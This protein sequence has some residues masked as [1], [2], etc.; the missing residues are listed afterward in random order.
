MAAKIYTYN[1]FSGL[2]RSAVYSELTVLPHIAATTDLAAAVKKNYPEFLYT[3]SMDE[4]QKEL[5]S[6][7]Q[8]PSAVFQQHVL[9]G[10]ILRELGGSE[11]HSPVYQSCL[12][13]KKALLNTI[14]SLSA[15]ALSPD[16]I[17]PSN[18]EMRLLKIIWTAFKKQAE[19]LP[20][21]SRVLTQFESD[22]EA[23]LDRL[24]CVWP[25]FSGNAVVM[26]GFFYITPIQQRL[27][28][29]FEKAGFSIIYLCCMDPGLKKAQEIWNLT[30]SDEWG[31]PPKE[32]W[33]ALSTSAKMN[34]AFGEIFDLGT[35]RSKESYGTVT[36]IKYKSELDFVKDIPRIRDSGIQLFSSD[37]ESTEKLLKAYYPESF[38]KRHLLSYPVGQFVY[39][40]Y[41]MW[42]SQRQ[43]IELRFE[44]VWICFSSGWLHSGKYNGKD[45]LDTLRNLKP[46]FSRC[47]TPADWREAAAHIMEASQTI[48]SAFEHHIKDEPEAH[49]RYHRLMSN[50]FLN[51]SCFSVSEDELTAVTLLIKTLTDIAELLFTEDGEVNLSRHFNSL[52]RILGKPQS[53][54]ALYKEEQEIITELLSR[55]K[56]GASGIGF[57]Y[58]DDLASAVMLIIGDGILDENGLVFEDEDESNSFIRHLSKIESAPLSGFR[59]IHLCLCDETRMPGRAAPY[60]WPLSDTVLAEIESRLADRRKLYIHEMRLMNTASP[61][62][63]RYLFFSLLQNRNVEISW[64]EAENGKNIAPSPYIRL[65]ESKFQPQFIT[66]ESGN[67]VASEPDPDYRTRTDSFHIQPEALHIPEPALDLFLCRWRYLYGYIL[68]DHPSYNSEFHYSFVL[69]KLISTL[70]AASNMSKSAIADELFKLLPFYTDIERQQILDYS[71]HS[72][73]AGSYALDNVSYYNTRLI[74]HLLHN[75][76]IARAEELRDKHSSYE[77]YSTFPLSASDTPDSGIC[78]YCPYEENCPHACRQEG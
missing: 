55:L 63:K 21:Y 51:L 40:L 39:R 19:R 60:T 29:I 57:C 23:L 77:E 9:L 38:K 12:K 13:N 56:Q 65:L 14:R 30:F 76:I 47:V 73:I 62:V 3:V 74:P 66:K 27:I 7:W 33:T 37:T 26:H 32:Q 44:D 1:S 10:S 58:A 46:V 16:D 34:R 28:D 11:K 48:N 50:P 70:S 4:L 75:W 59:G 54:E 35:P 61:F 20:S 71:S 68:S 52:T 6:D 53:E 17:K 22:P 69:S 5:L 36:I 8:S 78:M 64:T 15:A 18:E 25:F 41:S 42:N 31:F 72:E 24:R 49:R 43:Q 2:R 67:N 45:Y